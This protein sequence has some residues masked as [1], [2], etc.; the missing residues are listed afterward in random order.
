MKVIISK[1]FSD[2]V[3]INNL[4][5]ILFTSSKNNWKIYNHSVTAIITNIVN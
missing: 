3:V 1:V 4:V 5:Y 2:G